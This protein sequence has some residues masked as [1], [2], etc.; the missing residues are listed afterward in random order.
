MTSDTELLTIIGSQRY[1]RALPSNAVATAPACVGSLTTRR[2]VRATHR[3]PETQSAVWATG[4]A[5]RGNWLPLEVLYDAARF[6]T[7]LTPFLTLTDDNFDTVEQSRYIFSR[8]RWKHEANDCTTGGVME[9]DRHPMCFDLSVNKVQCCCLVCCTNTG[10][11][12]RVLVNVSPFQA[13]FMS[14]KYMAV[15]V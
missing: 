11:W 5:P 12:S 4:V 1:Q 8:R 13:Q 10:L 2:N 7:F 6:V 9:R 3:N 14:M 15:C